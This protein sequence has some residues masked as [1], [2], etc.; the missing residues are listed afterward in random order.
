MARTRA[1]PAPKTTE[2]LVQHALKTAATNPDAN[3]TGK[4]A[5][6]LFNTKEDN[7]QAAIGE[8]TSSTAPLLT[9]AGTRG[10]L[11][12]AGF[13]KIASE[14]S[15]EEARAAYDRLREELPD[16][17][18]GV[19]ARVM[20]RSLDTSERVEFIQGV[21]RRTPLASTELV[22]LLEEAVAAEKAESAA[23]I[24]AAEKR[25]VAEDAA[26]AALDR[27]KELIE[28]RRKNRIDALR[29]EWEAEG[30]N[31]KDLPQNDGKGNSSTQTE[32]AAPVT[33]ADKDYRKLVSAQLAEMWR[34]SRE[35]NK[36]EAAEYLGAALWN[37]R[38]L[39]R[40]GQEKETVKFNGRYHQSS[41]PVFTDDPVRVLRSGWVL[42]EGEH[43]DVVLLKCVV[44]PV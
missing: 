37:I 28:E 14:L 3:W 29:R 7:H 17:Q 41:A 35:K 42:V 6:A 39:R 9:Q 10:K 23:R 8:C 11:T 12:A 13:E 38:G 27:A 43:A 40:E 34:Q 2:K 19:A 15:G 1:T 16:E 21:I 36:V 22:P 4:S 18:V 31:T 26:K 25:R 20:A 33:A 5:S 30:E 32:L 44:E 24:A